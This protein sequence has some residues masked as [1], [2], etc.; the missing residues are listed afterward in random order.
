MVLGSSDGGVVISDEETFARFGEQA[1][2]EEE[3]DARD[4]KVISH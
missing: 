4:R 2:G 1:R 3:A